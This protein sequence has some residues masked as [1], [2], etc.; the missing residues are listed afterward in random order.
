MA[1]AGAAAIV[2]NVKYVEIWKRVRGR[3]RGYRG[4]WNGRSPA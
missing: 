3:W 2:A 1:P 4:M